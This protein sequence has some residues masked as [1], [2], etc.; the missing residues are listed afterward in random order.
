M[1]FKVF[2]APSNP[3]DSVI[4]RQSCLRSVTAR[5]I[6]QENTETSLQLTSR[7]LSRTYCN[8]EFTG[9]GQGEGQG[10]YFPNPHLELVEEPKL[11][12]GALICLLWAPSDACRLW[13]QVLLMK[14]SLS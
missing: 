3:N 11:G 6:K 7:F 4:L 1:I 13:Q 9:V 8:Q 5:G 2:K 14:L 10:S 12:H